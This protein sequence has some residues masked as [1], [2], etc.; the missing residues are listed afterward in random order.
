MAVKPEAGN[1]SGDKKTG[2]DNMKDVKFS[3]NA[4]EK[5]TRQ[6]AERDFEKT[7]KYRSVQRL[8]AAGLLM[9]FNSQELYHGRAAKKG[10]D[11]KWGVDRH[12][13]NAGNATGHKNINKVAALNVGTES[14]ARNYARLRSKNEGG[15]AELHLIQSS[16]PDAVVIDRHF[17][18]KKKPDGTPRTDAEMKRVYK[19]LAATMPD[20]TAAVPLDFDKRNALDKIPPNSFYAMVGKKPMAKQYFDSADAAKIAKKSGVDVETVTKLCAALNT[21]QMLVFDPG[22]AARNFLISREQSKSNE[23]YPG[24][25]MSQEYFAAW[26]Q[27]THTIGVSRKVKSPNIKRNFRASYLFELGKIDSAENLEAQKEARWKRTGRVALRMD[28]IM[29]SESTGKT[30]T[31]K[32]D[33]M[34]AYT[35]PDKLIDDAKKLGRYKRIFESPSGVR[36]GYTLQEHTETVL[37]NFDENYADKVPAKLVP[38][39]HL[40]LTVHDIGKPEAA[41]NGE[42]SN[43]KVYNDREA[44]RFMRT[45][46]VGPHTSDL[47]RGMIGHA[48]ELTTNG[49]IK[50]DKSARGELERYCE[51]LLKGVGIK[52]PTKEEILGMRDL[53]LMIQTCD[54]AAYTSMARTQDVKTGIVYRNKAA[55][56]KSFYRPTGQGR[57]DIRLKGLTRWIWD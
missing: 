52:K 51:K 15:R 45:I 25:L 3:G 53:C 37:R 43:Q 17:N 39:M 48:Q 42:K 54:S 14:V 23:K 33:L 20:L 8:K 21:R 32:G 4:P 12:Y 24:A 49:F 29:R 38:L 40:A 36:E 34:R 11:G 22:Y 26:S 28:R 10:E 35:G 31:F 44:E 16:D 55:F 27:E 6:E 56:N 13:D 9:D 50:G 18:V 46:G 2:W 30:S 5:M 41:A 47:V 1:N 7:E 19:D 57:R